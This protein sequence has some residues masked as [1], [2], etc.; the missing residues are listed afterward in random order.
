MSGCAVEAVFSSVWGAGFSVPLIFVTTFPRVLPSFDNFFLSRFE[1]L[2]I[3]GVSC[4]DRTCLMVDN[5][6]IVFLMF[7]DEYI[8]VPNMVRGGFYR[9]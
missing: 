6:S 8:G 1:N 7:I 9:F 4:S 2:I 5:C 3:F